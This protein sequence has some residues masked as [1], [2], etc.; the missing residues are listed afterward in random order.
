MKNIVDFI[1]EYG[2]KDFEEL[3]FGEVDGLILSQFSYFR[4][5]DIIPDLKHNDENV[6]FLDMVKL[7]DP[8]VGYPND[9]YPK[10]ANEALIEA[11]VKSKRYGTMS[12]NYMS[13]RTSESV[14]TQF[15][16]FVCFLKGTVPVV[17]FRGTDSTI[18]GW[19]EDFNMAFSKPVTGQRLAALYLNQAG[20]RIKGDFI[21]AGHSKGGN[22][23]TF[24]A[25]NSLSEIKKRIWRIYSFDGP[26]FRP[27]ILEG[28]NYGEI[29]DRVFKL[30]PQ[31]S[32][33]GIILDGDANFATV[34]SNALGGVLQ[35][36]PYTW[37]V[38]GEA[39]LR[40][41]Y[42]RRKSVVMHESLNQWVMQLDEEQLAILVDTLFGVVGAAEATT[43][44]DLLND[45]K[46]NLNL[47]FNAVTNVDKETWN[48]L[49]DIMKE[50]IEA[51][52]AT[53]RELL[54]QKLG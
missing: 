8:Q 24:A 53:E 16:A 48:E 52:T 45:W 28:Y 35:H 47:I 11:M 44:T 1:N 2:D 38:E 12:C 34:K 29:E 21:V 17:V 50:L 43:L 7:I 23:A 41:E 32:I 25:M 14:E 46:K 10:D 31:S 15:A 39:F 40:A 18:I 5:D 22:F 4:W 36:N 54:E 6:S 13:S 27:E 33:V 20:L 37:M 9:L 3:P 42:V 49:K 51:V 30:I 19:K 26:G